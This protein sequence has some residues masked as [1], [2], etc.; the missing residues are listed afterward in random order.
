MLNNRSKRSIT[1]DL[2]Q[3]EGKAILDKLIESADVFTA[4]SGDHEFTRF[5]P[6]IGITTKLSEQL[7][8][9]IGYAETNR[10]PSPV[11]LTC[12]DPADPC[13]LPNAFLA[14]P[15]LDVSAQSS[16]RST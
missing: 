3:A 6:A 13:R 9:Y 12:A 7:G 15:P 16:H 14:Y 10:T 5:N 4:L 11:E 8:A 1:L 2:K